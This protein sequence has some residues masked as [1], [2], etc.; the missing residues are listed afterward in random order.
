VGRRATRVM[1]FVAVA[2]LVTAGCAE[3][4]GAPAAASESAAQPSIL[5][6][7]SAAEALAQVEAD[8]IA[9]RGRTVGFQVVS[10]GAFSAALEGRLELAGDEELSLEASGAFGPDSVTLRV[11]GTEGRMLWGNEE[12]AREDALPPALRE[13][14]VIG[15]VRF[16]GGEMRVVERY[17]ERE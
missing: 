1:S 9:A 12:T 10:E 16:P 2:S 3:Q 5:E 17:V 15:L 14:V 11:R 8:L 6:L 13:A 4:A 7:E